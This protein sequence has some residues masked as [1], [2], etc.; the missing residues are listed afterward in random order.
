MAEN[1][2]CFP[3]VE[4]NEVL[5]DKIIKS[6]FDKLAT[7]TDEQTL[8][9]NINLILQEKSQQGL[10]SLEP[11]RKSNDVQT[12]I[13]LL[14]ECSL[15]EATKLIDQNIEIDAAYVISGI[16]KFIC[17]PPNFDFPSINLSFK[18]SLKDLFIKLL[19]QFVD[20]LTQILLQIIQQI[21]NV[22]L[23]ICETNFES[24][25]LKKFTE[26]TYQTI[27]TT[28]SKQ[29]IQGYDYFVHALYKDGVKE[30]FDTIKSVVSTRNRTYLLVEGKY[31]VAWFETGIKLLGK[32]LNYRVIP[33][34]GFGNI[35]Y[36]KQQLEKE[37]FHTLVITDGDVMN[38]TSLKKDIIELYGDI[39]YINKRFHTEFKKMPNSKRELFRAVSVKDDVVK[40][41]LSSWSR[42]GLTLESEFV[43]E[44]HGIITK[45]ESRT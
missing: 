11:L 14:L 24:K 4:F 30:E 8:K 7:C 22:V 16:T 15:S 19:F 6:V 45:Y 33:C 18:F 39:D 13:N 20:L 1:Q 41:V 3:E 27:L 36:V 44:L 31:D 26:F 23:N 40:K 9:N 32:Q 25:S 37:G 43:K 35:E 12:Q 17:N 42:K 5:Q 34:G 21:I 29:V 2:T 10:I 28:R 38:D